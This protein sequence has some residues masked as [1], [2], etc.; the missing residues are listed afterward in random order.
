M[1]KGLLAASVLDAGALIAFERG[2]DRTRAILRERV[3][4]VIIPATV[5]AEVWRGGSRQARLARLIAS[6]D[7]LIEALD[8]HEAKAVGV[9]LGRS[10]TSDITDAHVVLTARARRAAV[11]T[12][13]AVDLRGIDPDLPLG[14]L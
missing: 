8:E 5:L 1:G 2:D 14:E 13:D 12:G 9:L 7:V 11:L 10:N 4:E 3:G 6:P